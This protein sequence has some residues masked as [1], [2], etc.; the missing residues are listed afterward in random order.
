MS[1]PAKLI[2]QESR[3][4]IETAFGINEL[5]T[6]EGL[7]LGLPVLSWLERSQDQISQSLQDDWGLR[8]MPVVWDTGPKWWPPIIWFK[9]MISDFT[10]PE[11]YSNIR[12]NYI[13]HLIAESLWQRQDLDMITPWCLG[14]IYNDSVQIDGQA[15]VAGYFL[16]TLTGFSLASIRKR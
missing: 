13:V 6:M 16:E 15:E 11:T 9:D 7:H 2:H 5:R 4:T 3:N 10:D 1:D 12:W 8:F 14:G